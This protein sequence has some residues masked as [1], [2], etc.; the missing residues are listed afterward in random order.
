MHKN[1]EHKSG[2]NVESV[3]TQNIETVEINQKSHEKLVSIVK[4]V[5]REKELC[6]RDEQ[7]HIESK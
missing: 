4:K 1:C 6:N 2:Y 7:L 3:Q 5:E